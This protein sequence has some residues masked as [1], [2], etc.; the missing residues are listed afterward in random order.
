MIRSFAHVRAARAFTLVEVLMAVL[1][2]AIG[3]LGLGAVLP[4]VVKQQ[5][6]SA[7]STF[8]QLAADSA[9]TL[10]QSERQGGN[11]VQSIRIVPQE[12]AQG[13]SLLGGRFTLAVAGARTEAIPFDAEAEAVEA[14]LNALPT[15]LGSARVTK[16]LESS[17]NVG[18]I[19][20]VIEFD[21]I[22]AGVNVPQIQLDAG[23]LT[24]AQSAVAATGSQGAPDFSGGFFSNWAADTDEGRLPPVERNVLPPNADWLV[25][26]LDEAVR[27]SAELGRRSKF[28]QVTLDRRFFI[29]LAERL[30]PSETAGAPAPQFVYDMAV[31][32]MAEVKDEDWRNQRVPAAAQRVQVALFQRRIDT[33]INLPRN[34][35]PYQAFRVPPSQPEGPPLRWPVS[36][37]TAG[38]PTLTG[39]TTNSPADDFG[40]STLWSFPV[41]FAPYTVG[42]ETRRDRLQIPAS[43]GA[44]RQVY[45]EYLSQ[46]GQQVVDNL[47][48]VYTVVGRAEGANVPNF[49]VIISPPVAAGLLA[50]GQRVVGQ[51]PP[52]VQQ[53]VMSPQVP[54]AVT[55]FVANP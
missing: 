34:V 18:I 3:L 14:A 51:D 11:E 26:P 55:V 10:F 22:L 23:Q 32:R 50:T 48:N 9:R 33:R 7:D 28:G 52:T 47:G 2:L 31:R 1:V 49:S 12:D 53:V 20:F 25:V 17:G 46:P 35:R 6:D 19:V 54:A 4:M 29:P 13:N 30:Y 21:G 8:G 36:R 42:A 15:V 38:R 37:D 5:R 39:A 27:G 41:D 16:T 43:V 40:Y 45:F 24:G 44:D